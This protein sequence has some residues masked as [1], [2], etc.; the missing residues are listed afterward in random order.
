MIQK[1][2]ENETKFL[3]IEK[4][5]DELSR[6][7]F[8]LKKSLKEDK[9]LKELKNMEDIIEKLVNNI[10]IMEDNFVLKI[11][12][13]EEKVYSIKK[14]VKNVEFSNVS[15]NDEQK[16]IAMYKSGYSIEDISKELRIPAGEVEFILKMKNIKP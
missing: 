6:E 13:L 7:L 11:K 12:E 15:G 16:I 3:A 10:K 14:N 2:K 5:L 1:E 8:I 9:D 4:S